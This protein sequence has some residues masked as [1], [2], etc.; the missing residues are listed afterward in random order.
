M[1]TQARSFDFDT[2]L[3]I[4]A[5]GVQIAKSILRARYPYITDYAEDKEM[6]RRGVD[7]YVEGLGYLEVKTDTHD[8]R[9]LFF[10]LAVGDKPGAV[11]RCSA[12]YFCVLY[13]EHRV[14]YLIP[15]PELQKWLREN[16]GWIERKRPYWLKDTASRNEGRRWRATGVVIPRR[17]L[18]KDIKIAVIQWS[19]EDERI[20]AQWK[21]ATNARG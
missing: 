5:L 10:E 4:G 16:I 8:P 19:E 13:P 1:V 9:R 12:D 21:E 11:D 20:T 6:Q 3:N 14:I 15:R 7:L 2:Q 18:Q 17:L